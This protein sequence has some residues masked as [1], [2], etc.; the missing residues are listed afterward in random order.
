MREIKRIGA[1]LEEALLTGTNH[2]IRMTCLEYL[3]AVQ[4]SDRADVRILE[5]E[6]R[7]EIGK[8]PIGRN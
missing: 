5:K 4:E 6:I 3:Q 8:L 1:R 7:E 2:E